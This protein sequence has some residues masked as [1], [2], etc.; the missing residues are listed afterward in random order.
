[1]SLSFCL[2][3]VHN[4]ATPIFKLQFQKQDVPSYRCFCFFQLN[5][6]GNKKNNIKEMLNV[7]VFN[8]GLGG[9]VVY[10]SDSH[11]DGTGSILAAA[12]GFTL[13]TTDLYGGKSCKT[14]RPRL[15]ASA[16]TLSTLTSGRVSSVRR[17]TLVLKWAGEHTAPLP[18]ALW[19]QNLCDATN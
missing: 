17:R 12:F 8:R 11:G 3:K 18:F 1:M 13:V 14:H 15:S 5:F 6:W 2:R 9:L 16:M 10:S 4:P 19:Q 7:K